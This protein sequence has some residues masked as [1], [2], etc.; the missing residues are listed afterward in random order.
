MSRAPSAAAIRMVATAHLWVGLLFVAVFLLTGLYMGQVLDHL[1]GLEDGPRMV[2]RSVHVYLMLAALMNV[3]LGLYLRPL[4]GAIARTLQVAGSIPLLIA[5]AL[6]LQAFFSEPQ[7]TELARPYT[8]PA[9]Y[10]LIGGTALHLLAAPLSRA[11]ERARPRTLRV[12]PPAG[13]ER[14]PTVGS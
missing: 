8:E 10:G 7:L 3:A 1:R 13:S 11:R 9:L 5:P 14:R 6:L 2:F 12:G 4:S